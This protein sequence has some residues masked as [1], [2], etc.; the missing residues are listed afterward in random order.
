MNS[1]EK[2][3]KKFPATVVEILSENMIAINRGRIHDIKKGDVFAIY[4]LSD[5]EIKDPETGESLGKLEIFRGNGEVIYLQEKMST[6]RSIEKKPAK[7][8]IIEDKLPLA[9]S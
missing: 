1:Q 9:F 7:K 5:D 2:S 3:F 6:L 8:E 4:G